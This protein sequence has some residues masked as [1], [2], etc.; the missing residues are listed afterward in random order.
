MT[1][2]RSQLVD[3]NVTPYYHC[4]SRCVRQAF[5]CG[6]GFEHR[7]QWIE[8]RLQTLSECFAVSVCGFAVMDNHLHVLV[9]LEPDAANGWSAEDVVRRWLLAYPSKSADGQAI[10]VTQAWIDDLTSDEQRVDVLRARLSNL[11]WFMKAL[12]E[13]LARMANKEDD[14][15]GTFWNHP[16]YYTPILDLTKLV[17]KQTLACAA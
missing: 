12:K 4:I 15:K 2:T 17:G 9:R 13:P 1:A 7:K 14:C 16:S 3:V 6:E 5:L 10:E 8:D 11:G